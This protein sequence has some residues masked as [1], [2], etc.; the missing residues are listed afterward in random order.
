MFSIGEF[1]KITGL[2]VKTLRFYQEQGL[3]EPCWVDAG[4]GYRYYDP[5]KLELARVIVTL[6]DLEFPLSDIKQILSTLDDDTDYLQFLESRKRDIQEA[7]KH[8]RKVLSMLDFIIS[9]E[10]EVTEDMSESTFTVEEKNVAPMLVASLRM[11]GRYQECGTGFAKIGKALGRYI[12]GKAML[13]CLDGEYREEDAN[14]EVAMPVSK[15]I[16]KAIP[17]EELEFKELD[18]GTCIALVHQ[19]PYEELWRSYERLLKHAKEE[20]LEY[21]LPTREVYQ[22]GPG[23]IFKGDPMKYLTE[24]QLF[25]K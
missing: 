19:G 23:M 1:S 6:R 17:G 5:A 13:L 21:K 7:L 25:L 15:K 18:G 4:S 3:L 12:N 8:Q 9:H 2:T 22:K 16:Q 20:G 10:R 11:Q 14:F 24:I